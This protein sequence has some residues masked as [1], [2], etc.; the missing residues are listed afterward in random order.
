M[1]IARAQ[2]LAGTALLL[3]LLPAA[4]RAQTHAGDGS[5]DSAA[6]PNAPGKTEEVVVTAYRQLNQS[7]GDTKRRADQIVDTLT[8]REIERL[9][10]RSLAEVLDRLPGVSADRGFSSSQARTV[11]VRGF[12]ARY[13]SMEV[14]GNLIWNSSRNNRGTQLDVFPASVINQINVY[15]TVL[16]DQDANSIGGHIELRTL[17]AFD[18]GTASYFK[19]RGAYGLYE[20]DG[21]PASGHPSLRVDG[22]AKFTFGA[23]RQFGVV[24]GGEFQQYSF[25]DRYNE[26]TS[27][28]QIGGVNV[29]NGDIF[30]GVFPTEQRR[31]ALFGKIET[32]SADHYYG[33]LS[34]SYFNDSIDQSFN[35]GGTFITGTRVTGATPTSG[36]FTKGTGETYF[37]QYRLNRESI[38][39]GSG[40]DYR[41]ADRA[42]LA[43]RAAYTRYNHDEALFRSERFQIGSLAGDYNLDGDV[44]GVTLDAASLAAASAPANWLQRTGKAAFLQTL[45]HR[46]NV[47][48]ASAELNWNAQGGARGLG[49]VG[50][51]AWRRLDR[52]FNQ[53]TNNYTIPASPVLRLSEVL[54][55]GAGTQILDGA[56]PAFIDQTAYIAWVTAHGIYARDDAT[57]TDYRLKEDVLAGHAAAVFTLPGL[58]VLAGF[59]VE[60]TYVGDATASTISG[61]IT[62]QTRRRDYQ[63]FMPNVQASFEPVA[64]LKLRAAYTETI[65]RPDFADFANGVTVTYNSAGVKVVSGA[66]PD[67]GPRKAKNYDASI[68]GYFKGGYVSLGL[69]HKNLADETFRQVR[70]TFDS[71]G[72]LTQID[73]IPLNSGSAKVD[74]LEASLVVDKFAF[75]PGPL[76]NL[77]FTGN[78]TLLDGTWN[79]VFTDGT[80]RSVKGLR[81][82][83]KWLANLILTYNQ[84]RFGGNVGYRLRGRTFTGTFGATPEAD[85]WIDH[86]ARLD[87]QA[88]FRLLRNLTVFG[89]AR[90]LTNSYWIEDTGIGASAP[91]TTTSPGRSYW[92][93]VT[94]KM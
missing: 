22:A 39:L 10:D 3:A 35:R 13:N 80:A 55:S 85:I 28:S 16:P 18:G 8:Q 56:S 41:I 52:T 70:N 48:N 1:E 7:P 21:F 69:F 27:Y 53:T 90:N 9:P 79:V 26:V 25:F 67:L 73:T 50:G 23:N 92:F 57:T 12:D 47:Y 14:D 78:Y 15:K 29:A 42:S 31:K 68:E 59:R 5:Q 63:E 83:P 66:N 89:E 32:R 38:L 6:G 61:L 40:L 71:A 88:T 60:K 43:L 34:V 19:L 82:Q 17:R 93:G 45:P 2:A 24:L 58:R 72:V 46:D 94:L 75:L 44:P 37:E 91:T 36:T 4:V 84:G 30:H 76:G 20:Q 87:A 81:N 74:G 62:P 49:F 51:V 65:A 64:K 77:G 86:Y 33:F 54:D 11:T